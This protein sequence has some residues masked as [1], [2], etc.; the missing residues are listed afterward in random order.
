MMQ[1]KEIKNIL[2]DRYDFTKWR[3]VLDFIFPKIQYESNSIVIPDT[4]EMVQ[5]IH[6][7]GQIDLT[8]HKRI[9]ILEIQVK[10][11]HNI[12]R[13]KVGFNNIAS[14]YIDQANNHGLLV[15]Y[16]SEDPEQTNY[17]LSFISKESRFNEDGEFSEFTTNPKR[18]TYLL[19]PQE[20]CSTATSRFI[21]L[22]S[23]RNTF[24][25]VLQDVI[26]KN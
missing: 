1:V 4:S 7:K 10:S 13:T 19:G 23:K 26:E 24:D 14:K 6:Q 25:F 18:Y 5:H 22:A 17:R 12:A 9:I 15:F 20:A 2:S 16:T 8:D 11:K 21:E 3:S